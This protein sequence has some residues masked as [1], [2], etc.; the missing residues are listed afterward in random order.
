MPVCPI[1]DNSQF[2]FSEQWNNLRCSQCNSAPRQ[3]RIH[4]ILR[5]KV[6][7][8][9]KLRVH[10]FAPIRDWVK[11]SAER[12]S[13]SQF[14][15]NCSLGE[16]VNGFE[17][18]DIERLTYADA[19]IDLF[20]VEDLLE[21]IYHPDLAIQEMLRVL[22][23][24]GHILGTIPLEALPGRT[25]KRAQLDANGELELLADARYHGAPAGS[26]A[27]LVVWEYGA[28][29]QT[30]LR[31]WAGPHDISIYEGAIPEYEIGNDNRTTFLIRKNRSLSDRLADIRL[32]FRSCLHRL[33]TKQK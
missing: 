2:V 29:I 19:S 13:A 22:R 33:W 8:W 10:E 11:S 6:P 20:L 9:T 4:F 28:D 15:P 16:V 18:Q 17:N 24:G 25:R 23:P 14:Y 1:C 27:S 26:N 31:A 3:R 21:H 12:Y 32:M 7:Q 5:S 30:M